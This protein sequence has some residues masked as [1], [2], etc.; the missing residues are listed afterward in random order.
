MDDLKPELTSFLRE[1]MLMKASRLN[2]TVVGDDDFYQS[3][4]GIS[5]LD[6]ILLATGG[7]GGALPAFQ[8]NSSILMDPPTTMLSPDIWI[9]NKI[10][11]GHFVRD[12]SLRRLFFLVVEIKDLE[13]LLNLDNW[14]NRSNLLTIFHSRDIW[15]SD[16]SVRMVCNASQSGQRFFNLG[17]RC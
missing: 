10:H 11:C 5:G 12:V 3:S 14:Q 8:D 9:K 4:S 13:I 16:I 2:S 15:Q 6:Q 1:A 7:G 17:I